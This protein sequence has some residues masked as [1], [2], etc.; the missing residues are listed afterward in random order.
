M[1]SVVIAGD[2]SGTIT[3]AAPAVAGTTTL[4]LPATTGT[5]ALTSQIVGVGIGQTW[6]TPTRSVSTTYTNSTGKP[7]MVVVS[8]R[9][10]PLNTWYTYIYVD[11]VQVTY[12]FGGGGAAGVY[13]DVPASVIVP[14]GSTYSVTA[15]NQFTLWTELR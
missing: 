13:F 12:L 1:S 15:V 9:V 6:Q 11:G 14:N 8:G 3:L 4:T 7:I 2:T 5:V 10:N